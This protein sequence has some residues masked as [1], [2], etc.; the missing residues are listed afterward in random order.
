MRD[1][2]RSRL[3]LQERELETEDNIFI[4]HPNFN[5]NY[6]NFTIG[7]GRVLGH[8]V[9]DHFGFRVEFRVISGFGSYQVGS[10]QVSGHFAFRVVSGRVGSGIG[11]SIVRSFRISGRI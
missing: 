3:S 9:S 1:A 2:R 11:S 8:L 5:H 4:I 6:E 7:S 10:S